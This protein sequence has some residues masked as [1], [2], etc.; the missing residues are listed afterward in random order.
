MNDKELSIQIVE[1]DDVWKEQYGQD[2]MTVRIKE[3]GHF[4]SVLVS[5]GAAEKLRRAVESPWTRCDY[6]KPETLPAI[7]EVVELAVVNNGKMARA[8]GGRH[9]FDGDGWCWA[10]AESCILW[11]GIPVHL[12]DMLDWDEIETV[13]WKPLEPLPPVPES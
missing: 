7:G 10:R 4:G 13:F 6:E 12:E 11:G 1:A 9:D 2:A 5:R 8:F 3:R